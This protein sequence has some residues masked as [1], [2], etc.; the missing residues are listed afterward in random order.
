LRIWPLYFTAL[1][2]GYLVSRTGSAE[3]IGLWR[4]AAFLLLAGNWYTARHGYATNP[5][6]PLWS[7]SLEE[8][9]Y[10]VW[11]TVMKLAARR[12]LVVFCYAVIALGFGAIAWLRAHGVNMEPG[13]WTNS[14]AQF[15]LFALGALLA[16]HLKGRAPALPAWSRL[17]LFGAGLALWLVAESGLDIMW[18]NAAPLETC[19]GFALASLGSLAIFLS[20]FGMPARYS[21]RPLIYLGRI[22][23]GLYV[24]APFAGFLLDIALR[25]VS[26]SL[27]WFA[28][29]NFVLAIALASS[30]YYLLERPFLRLKGRFEFVH[31]RKA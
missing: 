7:I 6:A 23:Y 9:F 19:A 20:L 11:P 22:S 5:I 8:Q 24:F 17:L 2:L 15:P 4:M 31:S 12:M 28:C 21:P 18:G 14:L 27:W 25:G 16:I 3:W 13:I 26:L 10:V 1:F 29:A 30:S